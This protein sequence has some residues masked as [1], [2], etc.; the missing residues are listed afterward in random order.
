MKE[1]KLKIESWVE[2]RNGKT[3]IKARNK[4]LDAMVKTLANY[5]GFYVDD[6]M[7]LMNRNNNI[8][9]KLGTDTTTPTTPSMTALVSDLNIDPDSKTT[10]MGQVSAGVYDITFT[11]TW[12]AGKIENGTQIGEIGLYTTHACKT[13]NTLYQISAL[14]TRLSSADGDFTAFT[15][16]A[17][18]PLTIAY[19]IRLSY[20]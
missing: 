6:T 20:E 7:N 12:N 19:T 14:L 4:F 5:I 13:L 16:D 3:V 1:H 8:K 10:A 18:V 17:S 9:M 11:Q 2:I 15:V